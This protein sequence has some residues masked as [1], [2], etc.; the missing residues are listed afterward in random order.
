MERNIYIYIFE[1][2]R[3]RERESVGG[4]NHLGWKVWVY[5]EIIISEKKNKTK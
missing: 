3:E 2:E 5:T 4:G 1:R